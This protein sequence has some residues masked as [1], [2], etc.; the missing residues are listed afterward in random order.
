M[1]RMEARAIARF[2]GACRVAIGA[3]FIAYPPL[4]M[5]PW[6]GRDASRASAVLLSRALGATAVASLD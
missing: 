2:T 3:G 5:R 4:S 1:S 6:L